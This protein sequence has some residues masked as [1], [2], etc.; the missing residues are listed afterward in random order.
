MFLLRPV[1]EK[2]LG[3]D[4]SF[5]VSSWKLAPNSISVTAPLATQQIAPFDVARIVRLQ[6]RA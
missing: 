5:E 1:P 2:I 6:F 3:T 4:F